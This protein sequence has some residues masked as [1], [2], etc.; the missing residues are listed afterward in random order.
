MAGA[1][2]LEAAMS[3]A[4]LRFRAVLMTAT[5]FAFI[6]GGVVPLVPATD[7]R[8]ACRPDIG[9][10]AFAG[11]LAATVI[12]IILFPGLFVAFR[13]FSEWVGGRT[14]RASR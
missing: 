11:M 7:A 9:V 4:R 5:A 1:P 12:A 6:L 13:R 10:T 8:A 14:L 2:L 3:G